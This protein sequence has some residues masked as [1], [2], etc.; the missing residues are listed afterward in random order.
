M[1]DNDELP[2]V[3]VERIRYNSPMRP[4]R[5]TVSLCLT[6]LLFLPPLSWSQQPQPAQTTHPTQTTT[7]ATPAQPTRVTDNQ[8]VKDLLAKNIFPKAIADKLRAG[9]N[10][11]VTRAAFADILVRALQH[12]TQWVSTFPFYRDVPANHWAYNAIEVARERKL[13]TAVYK[14][15]GYFEPDR[16]MTRL[17]AYMVLARSLAGNVPSLEMSNQIL[18]VFP[19]Y[20]SVPEATRPQVARLVNA[21]ILRPWGQKPALAPREPLNYLSFA[22][23]LEREITITSVKQL[24][25]PKANTQLPTVSGGLSL[26]VIPNNALYVSQLKVGNAVFFTLTENVYDRDNEFNLPKGSRIR[27]DVTEIRPPSTFIVTLKQM[28][29]PDDKTYNLNGFV[30]LPFKNNKDAFIVPDI[31]YDAITSVEEPTV[32]K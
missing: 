7:P 30:A 25:L 26:P 3:A 19:D 21:R 29:T 28:N 6:A 16:P 17:E 4:L 2:D 20:Q 31:P 12:Q 5:L 10:P 27:G 24:L 9:E 15:P 11:I 1:Q 8:T 22:F 18:S 32:S 23:M 14:K 13:M